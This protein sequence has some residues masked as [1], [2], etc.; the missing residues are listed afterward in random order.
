MT[1]RTRAVT[2]RWPRSRG[3]RGFT[4][5]E[6]IVTVVILA[7]L[8]TLIVPSFNNASLSSKLS[9]FAND[10]VASAQLARSEAIKRNSNVTMCAS[11]DGDTCGTTAGWELGWIVIV[12]PG[13]ANERLLQAHSALP[14]EFR[15]SEAFGATEIDFPPTV[16]GTSEAAF[17]IRRAEPEGNQERCVIITLS[18]STRVS[19]IDPADDCPPPPPP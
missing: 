19:T 9:G 7:I 13:G 4:L 15:A 17:R 10:L 8:V 6:L 14:D 16:V 5:I 3:S 12:D 11:E 18:R 2:N 1:N